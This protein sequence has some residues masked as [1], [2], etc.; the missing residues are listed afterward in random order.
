MLDIVDAED[1]EQVVLDIVDAKDEE[2]QV[3]LDIVEA[4][5]EEEQVRINFTNFTMTEEGPFICMKPSK[6]VKEQFDLLYEVAALGRYDESF[7]FDGRRLFTLWSWHEDFEMMIFQ[8][9]FL[10]PLQKTLKNITAW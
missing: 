2:E 4:E 3:V 6:S 9:D 7:C 8:S 10:V 5:D 1:E